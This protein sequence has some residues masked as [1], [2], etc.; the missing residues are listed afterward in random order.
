MKLF[1]SQVTYFVRQSASRRNVR[2]LLRFLG[3]LAGMVALYSVLFH[4][5]MIFEGNQHSWLTGVYWTLTVMSTLGFGDITFHSDLGRF[6]SIVVLL[7]GMVFLLILLPFTFIEFFYAPW[8]QAQAEARAPRQLALSARGHVILTAYEPVSA[9]RMRK[10]DDYGHPYVLLVGDLQEAL[11]LHDLGV[12]VLFGEVDRPQTYEL[13]RVEQA[14]M[15][16]ATGNDLVNTNIAFTVRER[17]AHVPIVTVA[18]SRDSV[19]I[20]TLAGSSHVLELSEMMGS[21]LARRV[22]GADARAHVIGEFGEVLMVGALTSWSCIGLM[23]DAMPGAP[24]WLILLLAY[25]RRRKDGQ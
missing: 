15:V 16:V 14:A 5:L 10:L 20:L 13:A 11:R 12:K 18:D 9:S 23:Q 21:A 7:S 17:T 19:D 8:M 22:I 4:V 1:T 3:V 2:L 25:P 24:G 6:F